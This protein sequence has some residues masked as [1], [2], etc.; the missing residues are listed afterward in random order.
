LVGQPYEQFS[1]SNQVKVTVFHA[2]ILVDLLDLGAGTAVSRGCIL[3]HA[4]SHVGTSTLVH[5]G[6]DGVADALELLHV[7]IKLVS[8][9]QL[10][11]IKPLDGTIDSIINLLLVRSIL[12]L[13]PSLI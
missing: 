12:N 11:G 3:I 7:V 1:Q 2:T 5:L 9:C 13:L 6:N 4:T 10:V 8:L